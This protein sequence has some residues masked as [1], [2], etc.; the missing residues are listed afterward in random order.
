MARTKVSARL[1]QEPD[2]ESHE[3]YV[4]TCDDVEKVRDFLEGEPAVKRKKTKYLPHPNTAQAK[5]PGQ[6]ER[7]TA[8]LMG[9]EVDDFPSRTLESMLGR[10]NRN[11]VVYEMPAQIEYLEYD[12]DG[13]WSTLQETVEAVASNILAVNY[14]ILIAEYSRV[15]ESTEQISVSE[16]Q[17][18]GLRSYIKQYPRESL[19]DWQF[20]KINGRLQLV[21]AKLV[22]SD[23]KRA[24][25]GPYLHTDELEL[26][27]DAEGYR[28]TL[29]KYKNAEV[30][31]QPEVFIPLAMGKRLSYIP[32]EIITAD[33]TPKGTIPKKTGYIAPLVY[34][35][36]HRYQVSADLKEKLRIMQDTS[37][38][39]GWDEAKKEQFNAINGREYFA[40]GAG[41]HN[42]LPQE[43]EIDIL[44]MQADGDAHF[45]YLEMNA[46]EVQA[47]GG[48]FN[49]SEKEVTATEV[50]DAA[51][52]E[53][54]ELNL[55]A[56]NVESAFKRMLCYCAEFEGLKITPEKVEFS[57][58]REFVAQNMTPDEV[59]A[60][61]ETYLDGLISREQAVQ[62]FIDGGF[63]RG[64]IEVILADVDED[65]P[66]PGEEQDE[67][68]LPEPQTSV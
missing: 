17:V 30:I 39:S 12:T 50:M 7:Y 28:Q 36:H 46:G 40:F 53:L 26:F 65:L 8:Y 61:R 58:N 52:E 62:K 38:S 16:K 1:F 59:R 66:P 64:E 45:K 3:Q 32:I 20:G 21:Y 63:L 67:Q 18:M 37:Y 5:N 41:V 43:V 33:R 10:L 27:L 68:D 49:T 48:R 60:V 51:A 25:D 55:I 14:H 13:D 54:A 2:I 6:D 22:T 11:P 4:V 24:E 34:K 31:D 9:G 56:N 29:T 47:L 57:I 35:A 42:F 19:Y 23:V 15:P 44:K